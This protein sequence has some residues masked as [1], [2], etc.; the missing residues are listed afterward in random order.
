MASSPSATTELAATASSTRGK[1]VQGWRIRA[2]AVA[3]IGYAYIAAVGIGAAAILPLSLK[4]A[5]AYSEHPLSPV[6]FAAGITSMVLAYAGLMVAWSTIRG[7]LLPRPKIDGVTIAPEAAPDL[8]RLIDQLAT[9]L[10][11][12]APK[13]LVITHDGA[14]WLSIQTHESGRRAVGIYVGIATLLTLPK[15]ELAATLAHELA[16]LRTRDARLICFIERAIERWCSY[17][18]RFSQR[19]KFGALPM[20]LVSRWFIEQL[21]GPMARLSRTDELGADREAAQCTG[22]KP[23]VRALE[24]LAIESIRAEEVLWAQLERDALAGKPIPSDY[25]QRWLSHLATTDPLHRR[26]GWHRLALHQ[27]PADTDS[28]PTLAER[29][30]AV[31]AAPEPATHP[32]EN[33]ISLLGEDWSSIRT[34]VDL[35]WKRTN[36]EPWSIAAERGVELR[37]QIGTQPLTLEG[38][39]TRALA[40]EEIGDQPTA[41]ELLESIVAREVAYD[42]ARY[43]LGRLL[44]AQGDEEGVRHMDAVIE[45]D[46]TFRVAGVCHAIDYMIRQGRFDEADS[47]QCVID[48][49]ASAIAEAQRE[50][51]ELTE[52]DEFLPHGLDETYVARITKLLGAVAQIQSGYLVRKSL[53]YELGDCVYVLAVDAPQSLWGNSMDNVTLREQLIEQLVLPGDVEVAVLGGWESWLCPHVERIA[54]AHIFSRA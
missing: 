31:D 11:V 29:I 36:E 22:T 50:R 15:D 8:R 48:A 45:S 9:E 7:F 1:E 14:S 20:A 28:H 38:T 18:V 52:A 13:T 33:S 32:T 4:L 2:F 30:Y 24:R 51:S 42:K 43:H 54:G 16:H 12:R 46:E 39:L 49:S 40:L 34:S 6:P 47:Y 3:I 23:L 21:S 44:L 10:K 25:C 27:Q 26:V 5:V 19:R 41:I 17:A 37:R 53:R 35:V